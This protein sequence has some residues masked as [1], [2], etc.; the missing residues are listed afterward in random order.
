MYFFSLVLGAR[1]E[2]SQMVLIYREQHSAFCKQWT[3]WK[4]RMN[5]WNFP[6][7]SDSPGQSAFGW[8]FFFE[9][10]STTRA[11]KWNLW[12]QT[13]Q[14]GL[15]IIQWLFLLMLFAYCWHVSQPGPAGG[16]LSFTFFSWSL[17]CSRLEGLT[18]NATRLDQ[19]LSLNKDQ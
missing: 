10:Q 5:K 13:S 15:K 17:S 6:V 4:L 7:T 16:G 11:L 12:S 14:S 9:E 1:V 19:L 2:T 8:V 18:A 3:C